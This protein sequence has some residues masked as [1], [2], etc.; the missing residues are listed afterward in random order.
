MH[1]YTISM[2]ICHRGQAMPHS[3]TSSNVQTPSVESKRSCCWS[4]D[5]KKKIISPS[6]AIALPSH[7]L[8][9]ACNWDQS[10][11]I[12]ARTLGGC[13]I[14]A[15]QCDIAHGEEAV[16]IMWPCTIAKKTCCHCILKAYW[17][18]VA[19]VAFVLC[20]LSLG[21]RMLRSK[22][23]RGCKGKT[24]TASKGANI[25]VMELLEPLGPKRP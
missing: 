6:H 1:M 2:G 22:S 16:T 14:S 24:C 18:F 23:G 19:F 25:F 3:Q 20:F 13:D 21:G 10:T 4:C 7:D 15:S 11:S 12:H 8:Q 9:L 17:C 5:V